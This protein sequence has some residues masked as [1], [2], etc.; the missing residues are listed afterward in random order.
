ME[1]L[2]QV[3]EQ[4]DLQARQYEDASHQ[5]KTFKSVG[6]V[7]RSGSETLYVEAVQEYAEYLKE[8]PLN[9][10]TLYRAYIQANARSYIDAV[11]KTRYQTEIRLQKI[12]PML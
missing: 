5:Q 4:H 2:C 3:V 7:L 12:Y 10:Q 6:V 8:Y 1:I 9:P 11:G